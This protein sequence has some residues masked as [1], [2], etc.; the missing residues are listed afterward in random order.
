LGSVHFKDREFTCNCC[1]KGKVDP[2]LIA[3]LEVLRSLLGDKPIIIT[4]GYR[5]EKHNRK[6]G[7]ASGSQHLK[8]K[9]ADIVVRGLKPYQVYY[10]A[11]KVF[12]NGG[13]GIYKKHIHVDTANRRRWEG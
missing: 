6:V 2:L 12:A 8:G 10:Y 4:S 3:K 9:A 7:G 13:V 11:D 5:C 1:G